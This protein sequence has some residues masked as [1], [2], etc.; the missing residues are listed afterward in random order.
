MNTLGASIRAARTL[1]E[2]TQQDLAD[3][4]SI[5]VA[6]VKRIEAGAKGTTVII[7]ALLAAMAVEGV[8]VVESLNALVQGDIEVVIAKMRR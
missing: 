1:L 5:N 8:F 3:K 2:W 6:T 7:K 4:A